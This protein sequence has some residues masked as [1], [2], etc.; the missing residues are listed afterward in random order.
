MAVY[1]YECFT[2]FGYHSEE[3][4]RR[5]LNGQSRTMFM[6][7]FVAFL[8]LYLKTDDN[9]ILL[10]YVAQLALLLTITILYPAVYPKISRLVVNN[11]CMLVCV[12][13]VMLTR[14]NTTKAIKQFI[15]VAFGFVVS[16]F[17]PVIIR[18]VK[19]LSD[20]TKV[21]AIIGV[22][23]LALVLI[24]GATS[25]G[26][27][28]GFTIAGIGIQPSE[29]VKIVFVFF[30]ASSL[31]KSTEFK[32]VVITTAVAAAHVLILVVCKDLGAALIIFMVYLIMLYVA[33]R[34]PL[35]FAAGIGAGGVASVAA[36]YLFAHVRT[37][38]LLWKDPIGNYQTNG[39]IA[40]SLFAIGTGSWF[41]MGLMQGAPNTIPVA[42][43]DFI[44]AAITE[45]MGVI[46]S[47]CLIMVYLSC[48]IMFLNIAM[49]L[50]DQFYKLVALGLGTCFIF[51]TFLTIGG[52]IK[53][54]PM[55]GV[56]LP[57]VCYGGS[58]MLST[59]IMFAIIQ[60]LYILRE[61]EEEIIE[62]KRAKKL[63]DAQRRSA[64]KKASPEK[65]RKPVRAESRSEVRK[66]RTKE[67]E[68]HKPRVR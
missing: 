53:F 37:R 42:D 46:F 44:F 23:S 10:F 20:L 57:L 17:V 24:R 51:Q 36:Y 48:Y 3:K 7:H 26:A 5:I 41:G 14:L 11:M 63:R 67:K 4:K 32:N 28:L 29:L 56:T 43:E 13:F 12:G 22:I 1:T 19:Q 40:Q 16:M 34:Q 68:N 9:K 60:G 66:T 21:Y 38:V 39:Q 18:K 25:G 6:M 35:Y 31:K 2:V 47:L 61:D 50:R 65:N 8:V 55:T 49:Q 52:V 58:S 45:E 27:K 54:I 64:G 59:L 33:T 62:R 15:F 30:V